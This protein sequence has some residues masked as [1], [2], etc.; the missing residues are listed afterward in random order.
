MVLRGRPI[1]T[2]PDNVFV[3]LLVF[4]LAIFLWIGTAALILHFR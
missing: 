4:L 1:A 2:Q 3:V